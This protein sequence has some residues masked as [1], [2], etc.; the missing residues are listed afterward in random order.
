MIS[1]VGEPTRSHD[2]SLSANDP[3][4]CTKQ[5]VTDWKRFNTF[6]QDG[7]NF[8]RSNTLI[9]NRGLL[10]AIQHACSGQDPIPNDPIRSSRTPPASDPTHSQRAT[11]N[12]SVQSQP[13]TLTHISKSTRH[14][15]SV[16]MRQFSRHMTSCEVW[17]EK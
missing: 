1:V 16:M 9:R 12:P 11:R 17:V 13:G 5:W 4:T 10:Q 15:R 8:E 14:T 3:T 7:T 2:Q 6:L